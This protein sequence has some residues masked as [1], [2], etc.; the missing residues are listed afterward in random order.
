MDRCPLVM[1]WLQ[2]PIGFVKGG[3][4]LVEQAEHCEVDLGMAMVASRIASATRRFSLIF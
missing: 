2:Q 3:V 1:A 4:R